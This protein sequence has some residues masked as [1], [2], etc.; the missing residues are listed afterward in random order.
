MFVKNAWYCAGWDYHL[1][2]GKDALL[3]RKLAGERVVLYRKP[4]GGI[5]AMEDRCC[6]RQAALSRG[7]K[8]GECLRCMYHG[9]KYGPDG[10]CVEIPG[11]EVIPD[12]ARVRTYPVVEKHNWIWVWMGDPEKADEDLICFAVGYDHP[13]WNIKT[14]EMHVEASYRL[15]LA[16]LSDL[17]HLAWVHQK[18]LGAAD[19]TTRDAFT[20][21]NAKHT[22]LDRGLHTEYWV[23][24]VPVNEFMSHLF[25]PDALFDLHFDINITVPCNWILHFRVFTAGTNT[26]GES[27]GQLIADTYT[28]QSVS[29]ADEKSVEY[30]FSWGASK[31]T[32]FPGLSELLRDTLDEAF[33][34]DAR[35]LEAQQVRVAEKP[36]HP[37]VDIVHDAGPG[38]MLWVLDKL[39]K[40]ERK[41]AKKAAEAA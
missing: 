23:R 19:E 11:Q 5:V 35:V 9:I 37:M 7:Q 18:T 26:E 20:H 28:C 36:D 25:P 21:L 39:L 16:N 17:S 31:Q 30:Y 6:H 2:Q 1:T 29:P 10:K 14:S 3:A 41:E 13:D 4:D 12:K 38:K 40:K 8:E 32:D 27:N 34:E 24:S 22:I 15:E 33:L